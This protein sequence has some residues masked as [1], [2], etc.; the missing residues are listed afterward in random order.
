MLNDDPQNSPSKVTKPV[1]QQK[2]E[3][4]REREREKYTRDGPQSHTQKLNPIFVEEQIYVQCSCRRPLRHIFQMGDLLD[5]P[6]VA[7]D[8]KSMIYLAMKIYR[9]SSG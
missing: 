5:W 9:C 6:T 2:E 3:R 4:E 1:H 7:R 8:E